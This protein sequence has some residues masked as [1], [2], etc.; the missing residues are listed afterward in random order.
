MTINKNLWWYW[1]IFSLEYKV[2]I[3]FK[4]TP[5]VISPQLFLIAFFDSYGGQAYSYFKRLTR[6]YESHNY[7]SFGRKKR[8]G[9]MTNNCD[10]YIVLLIF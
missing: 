7:L 4:G 10:L 6:E 5:D 1:Q 9:Q 3:G 8:G 2:S